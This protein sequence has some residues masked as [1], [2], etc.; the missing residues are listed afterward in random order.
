MR[1]VVGITGA[2]GSIYGVSLIRVLSSIGIEVHGVCTNMG[3]KVMQFECGVTKNDLD[4]FIFWHK[5]DDLFSAIASGSYRVD[6]MV[7]VPC[8]MN[9][10]GSLAQGMGDN[11][12]CRAGQVM[13][14]EGRKFVVVPREMPYGIIQLENML[15]LARA[16][17]V[18]LP[19][20]PGFYHKPSNLAG[21]ISHV[22][23]KILDVLNIENDLFPRWG[24]D[25]H[26]S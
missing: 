13:L 4:K 16:G 18:I 21:L 11:L 15:R 10:L 26:N 22:I 12:L 3:E 7:V 5:N 23:G 2:S 24:E 6:A 8:S 1:V 19:A 14:K 9:T 25:K 20:S 17:A